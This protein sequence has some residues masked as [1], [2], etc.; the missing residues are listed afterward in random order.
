M[1]LP[2]SVTPSSFPFSHTAACPGH[3]FSSSS[4]HDPPP[5]GLEIQSARTT[6]ILRLIDPFAG[7]YADPKFALIYD[8]ETLRDT[9]EKDIE[10][11]ACEEVFVLLAHDWSLKGRIPEWPRE[12]N[13][14]ASEGWKEEWR[15]TFL[16]DFEGPGGERDGRENGNLQEPGKDA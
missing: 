13:G 3:I 9:L 16:E 8:D 2:D 1:P 14:W 12:L 15:W 10:L 11:D 4:P 6:P 7:S 5:A